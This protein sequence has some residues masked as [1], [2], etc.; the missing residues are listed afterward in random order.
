MS[1]LLTT[2]SMKPLADF[3]DHILPEVPGFVT[4]LVDQEMIQTARE[5]CMRTRVWHQTIDALTIEAGIAQIEIDV[6]D[7]SQ[8]F[9]LHNV[10]VS[11]A[12]I[13]PSTE[14]DLKRENLNWHSQ[15]GPVTDYLLF[16]PNV[17]RLYPIPSETIAGGLYLDARL[18]P[19]F[20]ATKLPSFLLNRYIRTFAAGVKANLFSMQKK[21]WSN[22]ERSAQLSTQFASEVGSVSWRTAK[23]NSRAPLRVR[24]VHK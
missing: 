20:G 18:V 11:D 9:E 6:P 7:Q 5:F 1:D 4:G 17:I 19:M 22:P 24:V 16:E 10:R 21:P 23:A 15:S 12:P 3:Y 8:V 14:E 13:T 2:H